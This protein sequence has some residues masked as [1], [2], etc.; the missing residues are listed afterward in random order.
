MVP[1]TRRR[2]W[3]LAGKNKVKWLR[4]ALL[5]PTLT[6]AGRLRLNQALIKARAAV[7]AGGRY[8]YRARSAGYTYCPT[9]RRYVYTG[10]G[11]WPMKKK[12]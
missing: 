6:R 12:Y 7:G 2:S 10:K 4:A 9:R 3:T 5:R 11:R 8:R 1:A